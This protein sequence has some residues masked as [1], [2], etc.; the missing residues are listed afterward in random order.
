MSFGSNPGN[1]AVTS[2]DTAEATEFGVYPILRTTD[3]GELA[4]KKGQTV[5]RMMAYEDTGLGYLT[6][7]LS[8]ELFNNQDSL[9]WSVARTDIDAA[10]DDWVGFFYDDAL[11]YTV[12]VDEG[13]TPNTYFLATVDNNAG[14]PVIT[15][16]GS[17][18]QP[19]SDFSTPAA[20]WWGVGVTTAGASNIQREA[21]GSGN[22]LVHQTN[23]TGVEEMVINI[24][25]GAIV[26]DPTILTTE[27]QV[28]GW[29]TQDGIYLKMGQSTPVI[30]GGE[31][32]PAG[33]VEDAGVFELT[34]DIAVIDSVG[35]PQMT[36][37]TRLVQWRDFVYMI[38]TTG[39]GIY[40]ATRL[41]TVTDFDA[42]VK[43]LY[44]MRGQSL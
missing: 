31:T 44:E 27:S 32:G 5:D 37:L 12:T 20:G 40:D 22:I 33:F 6:M 26:S 15:N 21:V 30:F 36:S 13:T 10:S 38:N 11:V 16:I 7:G 18:A 9:Q 35:L 29:K 39:G 25:T 19:G 41:W 24:T 17:G 28:M 43:T 14:T 1:V 4:F 34:P 23:G 3:I 42:F 2:T 8:L